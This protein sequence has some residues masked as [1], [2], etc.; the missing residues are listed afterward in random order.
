MMSGHRMKP[1]M[2]PEASAELTIVTH[3]ALAFVLAWT[4]GYERFYNEDQT[5]LRR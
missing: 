1:F 2:V 3:A 4:I 5:V